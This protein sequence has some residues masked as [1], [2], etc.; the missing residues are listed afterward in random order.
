MAKT[1][2]DSE[3]TKELSQQ[4]K[5]SRKADREAYV[6]HLLSTSVYELNGGDFKM[7]GYDS[8]VYELYKVLHN[9]FHGE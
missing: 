5:E 9:K 3:K 1:F 6:R 7:V 8:D 4:L 2:K